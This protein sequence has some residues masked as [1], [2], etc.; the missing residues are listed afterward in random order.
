MF[1]G[2]KEYAPPLLEITVFSVSDVITTSNTVG[3]PDVE[4]DFD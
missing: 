2:K 3:L 4:V 1:E